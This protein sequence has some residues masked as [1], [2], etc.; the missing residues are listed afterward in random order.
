MQ[1]AKSALIIMILSLGSKFLGFLR[2]MLIAAR[3]G[4]GMETDTG[5]RRWCLSPKIIS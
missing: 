5:E 2:D 1:A 4:S 3:F